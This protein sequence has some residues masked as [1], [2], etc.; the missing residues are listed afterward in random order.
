MQEIELHNSNQYLRAK[1]LSLSLS[2]NE[3]IGPFCNF[4]NYKVLFLIFYKI[5]N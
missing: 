3:K 2:L 5:L 1:V 4:V